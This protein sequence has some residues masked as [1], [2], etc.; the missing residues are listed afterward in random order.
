LNSCGKVIRALLFRK[1]RPAIV[2]DAQSK[3]EQAN[4]Y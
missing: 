1:R 4:A 3:R 2:R